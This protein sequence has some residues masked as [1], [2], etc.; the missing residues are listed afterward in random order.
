MATKWMG[1]YWVR[2][3]GKVAINFTRILQRDAAAKLPGGDDPDL[4]RCDVPRRKR[5]I[6]QR[7]VF[8]A[9]RSSG[10]SFGGQ[11]TIAVTGR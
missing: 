9:P 11:P 4:A 8:T 5:S 6:S 10:T 1:M 3:R 7:T 2:S